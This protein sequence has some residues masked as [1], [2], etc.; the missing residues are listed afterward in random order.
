L[1]GDDGEELLIVADED[2]GEAVSAEAVAES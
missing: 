1:I 2:D